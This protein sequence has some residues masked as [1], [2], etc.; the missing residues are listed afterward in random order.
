M[1]C[2]MMPLKLMWIVD[3]EGP[4]QAQQHADDAD[5]FHLPRPFEVG[6][7]LVRDEAIQDGQRHRGHHRI[8]REAPVASLDLRHAAGVDLDRADAHAGPQ[9]HVRLRPQPRDERVNERCGAELEATE[10]LPLEDVATR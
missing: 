3:V 6:I 10:H 2:S 5:V 8:A 1:L 4:P 9:F 7:G